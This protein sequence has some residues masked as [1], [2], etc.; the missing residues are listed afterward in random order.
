[1]AFFTLEATSP[2]GVM[3]IKSPLT[4]PQAYDR[5]VLLRNQGFV[6]IVAIDLATGR[7]IT[8]VQRLLR[9]LGQ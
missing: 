9:D 2:D 8:D 5:T 3:H 6:D 7:R 4:A 1:M